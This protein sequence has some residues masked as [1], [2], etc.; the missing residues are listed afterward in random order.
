MPH[1]RVVAHPTSDVLS[2]SC[3]LEFA[4]SRYFFGRCTEGTQRVLT[5]RRVRLQKMDN[6]FL[7][8]ATS[9]ADQ[10]G[11]LPGLMLTLADR[12]KKDLNIW[13]D[14][15]IEWACATLR[16]FVYRQSFRLRCQAMIADYT[17]ANVTISP[18]FI[19]PSGESPPEMSAELRAQ[20]AGVLDK[21]FPDT[22]GQDDVDEI[23]YTARQFNA[24]SILDVPYPSLDESLSYI[25]QPHPIR[26]RFQRDKAL[27]LGV[28][29]GPAFGKLTRGLAVTL[30]DGTEITPDQV[31]DP[32]RLSH[33]I[34]VLDLPTPEHAQAAAAL[35]PATWLRR[36]ATPDTPVDVPG[37]DP[38]ATIGVVV[39]LLGKDVDP[40]APA[41]GEFMASFGDA[42]HLVSHPDVVPDDLAF[43]RAAL[44]N[45]T[46]R[47]LAPGCFRELYTRPARAPLP[48]SD[49]VLPALAGTLFDIRPIEASASSDERLSTADAWQQVPY[50]MG[51]D[52]VDWPGM[53]GQITALVPS[54]EADA[55]AAAAEVARI[56]VP[57]DANPICS[58]AELLTVGT[59]SAL[60][61]LFRN[62]SGSLLR[63]PGFSV[64]LDCGEST[65][66]NMN[67]LYGP[68]QTPGVLRD[69]KLIF[70][71]HLHADHHLGLLMLLRQRALAFDAAGT[72]VGAPE[73]EIFVVAPVKIATFLAEWAPLGGFGFYEDVRFINA[74]AFLTS[75]YDY[76][77]TPS[78]QD[79]GNT[80]AMERALAVTT[81]TCKA[82]HCPA[83]YSVAFTFGHT[84]TFKIAYSGDTRPNHMFAKI[85][86][87]A[88]VLLHEATMD[89]ELAEEARKKRHS[90]LSEAL[91]VA[92]QMRARH[93]VLTH[94]SQR[95]PKIP[96]VDA[97]GSAA[98]VAVAFDGMAVRLRDVVVQRTWL[99]VL[100]QVY[101]DLPPE[102]G[103][104]DEAA[105]PAKAGQTKPAQTAKAKKRQAPQDGRGKK[106]RA[107]VCA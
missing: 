30:D 77:P 95:Y 81:V 65:Y 20:I 13:G 70:V 61:S 96:D 92:Q 17:D 102:E 18:E 98:N 68:D 43:T 72:T 71:S 29:P 42:K 67:K 4:S 25:I 101:K 35:P 45:L 91:S 5:E 106:A 26:G 48:P 100:G 103:E 6:I 107:G 32:P 83:A 55:A 99:P 56:E 8:G 69:V 39:H 23:A 73:R 50:T 19:S 21:M 93:V 62:V 46:L 14:R 52:G 58:G 66:A 9:W 57:A 54:F 88:D 36:L 63:L 87:D 10:M 40:H 74:G 80:A 28:P 34:I 82:I 86:L 104:D 49:R 31:V 38:E 1:L 78:P 12:G 27:A 76:A 44:Q 85:G 105:E 97:A 59:G 15:N 79:A 51:A 84:D 75:G 41:Y 37:E 47:T 11:G 3:T 90:T 22:A 64:V 94:F 7:T 33:R 53:L 89:D 60:P 16:H 24:T 2:G